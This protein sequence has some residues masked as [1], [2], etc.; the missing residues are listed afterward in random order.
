MF[1]HLKVA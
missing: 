1:V